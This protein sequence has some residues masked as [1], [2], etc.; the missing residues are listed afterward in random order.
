MD[1]HTDTEEGSF[2]ESLE[3]LKRSIDV[4]PS[5]VKEITSNLLSVRNQLA[6]Q[7]V[8]LSAAYAPRTRL[9]KWLGD[10][11]LSAELPTS[12]FFQAFFEEHKQENRLSLS[13][14]SIALNPSACTLFRVKQGTVLPILDFFPLLSSIYL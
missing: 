10:R 14:R 4:I 13:N 12:E 8:D 1:D 2:E 7:R 9:L 3:A 6:S 5:Q 11:T